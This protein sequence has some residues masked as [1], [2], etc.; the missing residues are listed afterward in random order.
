MLQESVSSLLSN[1]CAEGVFGLLAFLEELG[2]F[3][4]TGIRL[5]FFLFGFLNV[6]EEETISLVIYFLGGALCFGVDVLFEGVDP[7]YLLF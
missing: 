1:F 5:F 2:D 7:V 4:E 3:F 6:V